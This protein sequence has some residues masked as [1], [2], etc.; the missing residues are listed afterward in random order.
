MTAKEAA[1]PT[2]DHWWP[3]GVQKYWVNSER[4]IGVSEKGKAW[5]RKPGKA[6]A[7]KDGAHFIGRNDSWGWNF[8]KEFSKIDAQ[9]SKLI[10]KYDLLLRNNVSSLHHL[11]TIFLALLSPGEL[12]A[13]T[14]T[15][16][17][18]DAHI[19]TLCLFALSVAIR[20]PK[21]RHE[22]A[23]YIRLYGLKYDDRLG[24]ANI[25]NLWMGIQNSIP[26]THWNSSIA[27]LV[28]ASGREFHIGDG[29]SESIVQTLRSFRLLEGNQ[30]AAASGHLLFPLTPE[31]CL[32]FRLNSPTGK[33][34]VV[35][36]LDFE[37]DEIN[38]ITRKASISTRFFR[39]SRPFFDIERT[40]FSD[41]T[42]YLD[43]CGLLSDVWKLFDAP[44]L[45]CNR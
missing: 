11:R 44:T 37:I 27:F 19:D 22:L 34:V 6:T 2:R 39:H 18:P 38:E 43:G 5:R 26:T 41:L 21:F 24:A 40:E 36:T 42:H 35:S 20:S 33:S 45:H 4:N 15:I 7:S 25:H 16:A 29:F 30:I 10:E 12:G 1:K 9:A 13:R 32:F 23:Q 3:V 17:L 31:I 28:S 8:E 14:S